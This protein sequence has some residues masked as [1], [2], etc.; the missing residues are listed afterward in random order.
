MGKK[1]CL[2]TDK[3]KKTKTKKEISGKKGKKTF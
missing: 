2:E 3:L 1:I